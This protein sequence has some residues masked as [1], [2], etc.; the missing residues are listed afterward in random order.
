MTATF[1]L[2][3]IMSVK[4]PTC[5]NEISKEWLK[6][7]LKS[8]STTTETED[9]DVEVSELVTVNEKNGFLSGATKAK[10][11]INGQE[12][13][14]FIKAI[15]NPDDPFRHLFYLNN[16]D[17]VEIRFYKEYLPAIV[18]FTKEQLGSEKDNTTAIILENMVPKFYSGDFCLEKEQRG[19]YMIMDD[20]SS[21]YSM[22][23]G[24]E[25]LN[26]QQINDALVKIAKFHSATYA[27]NLKYPEKVQSWKLKCWLNEWLKDAGFYRLMDT[28]FDNFIKDLEKENCDLIKPVTNLKEKWLE[29]YKAS[30]VVDE[31]FISHGD[32]W[33]N[34]IMVSDDMDRSM[35][36]DWQNLAPDHP[37]ID[38]AFLLCTSLTPDNLNQW[39][40]DLIK[41][42]VNA[43]EETC[44]QFKTKIPFNIDEFQRMFYENGVAL[45]FLIWMSAYEE[46]ISVQPHYKDRFMWQ[47]EKVLQATTY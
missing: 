9:N 47:L 19:F 37:V 13:N 46:T 29:L 32:L 27:F 39:T 24:P 4:I 41:S 38:V 15:V 30:L 40:N 28:C 45:I 8:K 44:L 25:G 34:N 10:V 20:L 42:Y 12:K 31:R 35:I 33:I 43:F 36:L 1:N 22:K 7:V 26:F 16:F 17:E 6:V 2:H 21:Q 11:T 14:L 5:Q 23:T 18:Q 3:L